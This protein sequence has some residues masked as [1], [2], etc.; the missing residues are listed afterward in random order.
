MT[1]LSKLLTVL[2]VLGTAPFAA[3]VESTPTLP[4]GATPAAS[5]P[6]E[7]VLAP[8]QLLTAIAHSLQS[9]FGLVGDLQLDFANPWT[10]P[11]RTASVWG[12]VIVEYPSVAGASMVVRFRLFADSAPAGEETVVLRASLWA[13]AWFAREPLASGAPIDT[14]LIE[15]RR[16]DSFRM[17]DAIPTNTPDTEFVLSRSLQAGALLT[18][19][20]VG[21]RPLVKKGDIVEV[22]ASEGLLRVT[23]KALALQNGALGDVVTVRNPESLKVIPAQVVGE[24]RVEVRL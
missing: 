17:R 4:S 19:H 1:G 22:S 20:D 8:D 5:R 24:N 9:R 23:L 18:W 14:A 12:V 7:T 3:A 21:R 15:A 6:A 10:P 11:R 2:A 16:V 13:D